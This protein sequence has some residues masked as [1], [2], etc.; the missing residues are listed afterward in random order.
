MLDPA[1]LRP[2][3]FDKILL[4]TAPSEEGRLKILEIHTKKMPLAKNVDLKELA[5]LCEG[6]TGADLEAFVREAAMLSL[7]ENKEAKEVKK[8]HFDEAILKVKPSVTKPTIEVYKRI[9]ENFLKSA[10]AAVP[11]ETSYFG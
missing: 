3:R 7:R 11:L 5:K 8:K 6:Y 10:K 1:M 9:E 4:V 2:G